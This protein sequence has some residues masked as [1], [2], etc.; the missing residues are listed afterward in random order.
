VDFSRLEEFREF[1]DEQLTTTREVIAL[2]LAD[3]PRRLE[4]IATALA[5]GDAAALALAAHAL[6]GSAGNVGAVAMQREAAALEALARGGLP[7]EAAQRHQT[8]CE[9]WEATRRTL[10]RWP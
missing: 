2:F 7:A 10:A 5:T 4:G 9:L 1:D 8:L 3:A 6:K